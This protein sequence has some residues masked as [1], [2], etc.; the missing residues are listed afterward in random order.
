MGSLKLIYKPELS[1][2][3]LKPLMEKRN[4]YIGVYR[5]T[6]NGEERMDEISGDGNVYDLGERYFDARLCRMFSTDPLENEYPW[7]ST[8]A[9]CNNSPISSIDIK[10]AGD[11]KGT[12]KHTVKKGETLGQLAN[13]LHTTIDEIKR[14]NKD[15]I[16]WDSDKKRTGDKKDWIY[17]GETLN[18]PVKGSTPAKD[19]KAPLVI[20]SNTEKPKQD[21]TAYNNQKPNVKKADET[22]PRF[23]DFYSLNITIAVPNLVTGTLV[24]W[25]GNIS[26]DRHMQVY[27]SPIGVSVGKSA[28]VGSASLTANWMMQ[29]NKPTASET[30]DF[31]SGHGVSVGGGYI[32]GVNVSISPTN[33]GTKTALGFGLYTPQAGASYN[34]TPSSL[35]YNKK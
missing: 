17:E 35:I 22:G 29:S 9:Y 20:A 23:P 16:N 28:F 10:G 30:Y 19:N 33:K 31:L 25:S 24:G 21:G 32:G 6:Y 12:E 34:Y 5:Y 13:R 8:Y 1:I 3:S 7:Q 11:N 27:V 15:N 4:I 18:V 14:L 26:I 2:Y